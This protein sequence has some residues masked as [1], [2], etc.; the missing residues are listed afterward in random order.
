M[1]NKQVDAQKQHLKNYLKTLTRPERL[2]VVFY[3]YEEMTTA[4][5]A[6]VL[7]LSGSRV[8]QIHSSIIARCKAHLQESGLL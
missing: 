8:S 7:E 3:Y 2:I 1:S 4:E 6:K 5:I